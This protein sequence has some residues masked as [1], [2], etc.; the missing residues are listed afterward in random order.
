MP[1]AIFWIT[2]YAL[3]GLLAVAG[4]VTTGY[5]FLLYLA[6]PGIP[7]FAWHLILVS[8]R[9]ERRKLGIELVACGVLAL[10]APAGLWVGKGAPIPQG[11]L[12]WGLTWLQSAASIVYAYLRLEQRQLKT[13]PEIT[14][15]LHM[16]RRALLYASFNLVVV[17]ALSLANVLPRALPLPY[18]L[19]W[20]ET[21]WGSLRP[22]VQ[23]RPTLIGIR[24]LI[25]STLFTILFIFTWNV[26]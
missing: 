18:L 1:P 3:I 5:A 14:E 6:L 11:W 25:I 2:V 15:R 9:A 4:L 13:V 16:A 26:F 10:A 17:T 8:R 24:Q 19:Q 22:A 20:G 7:I 12:L 21:V 23:M